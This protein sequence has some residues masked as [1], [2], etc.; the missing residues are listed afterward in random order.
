MPLQMSALG[1]STT[2]FARVLHY[3]DPKLDAEIVI[4]SYDL[5]TIIIDQITK[6]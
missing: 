6:M 1:L 5:K 3:G 4:P 2:K